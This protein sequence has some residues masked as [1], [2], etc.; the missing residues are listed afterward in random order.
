MAA[1]HPIRIR[2]LAGRAT[3]VVPGDHRRT[4]IER[5]WPEHDWTALVPRFVNLNGGEH[6]TLMPGEIV[7][8]DVPGGS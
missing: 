1:D 4:L 5:L 6:R 7:F 3:V 2:G 8:L